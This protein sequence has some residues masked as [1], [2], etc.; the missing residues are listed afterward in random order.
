MKERVTYKKGAFMEVFGDSRCFLFKRS[1]LQDFIR[2]IHYFRIDPADWYHSLYNLK[3][4]GFNTVET[5]VPWNAHEPRKGQFDFSGRLDLER[6]IQNSPVPRLYMIVRPSPFYLCRVGIWWITSLALRRRPA[7]PLI[8]PSLY[9]SSG[10]LLW[11]LAWVV[12]PT[13]WIRVVQSSWCRWKMSMALME[14]IR[15]SSCN[16]GIWWRKRRDLSP[17]YIRWTMAS[18]A[19]EQEP[20]S[21]MTSSWRETSVP[22]QPITLVR[23]KNLFDEYGKKW[24]L[25]YGILG[26]LVYP[27]EGTRDSQ[28]PEELAEAVHEVLEL[29]SINLYMFHGGNQFRL[30]EWLLS[31]G[32]ARFATGDVLWLWGFAQWAGQSD[33]EVL[34]YSKN[35]GDL[36]SGFK[37]R[38]TTSIPSDR[39][40]VTVGDDP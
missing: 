16:S 31:S 33:G 15:L 6:F 5:Y 19:K 32:N 18:N 35:D 13:K 4:L 38:T 30:H 10:S 39:W 3:A 17:L 2:A 27:L 28:G 24:P 11:S 9:R 7:N 26:W 21:K 20:W 25:M 14:R 8:W 22:K 36:L 29:G 40:N 34:C 23:C 1:T 12:D 37:R